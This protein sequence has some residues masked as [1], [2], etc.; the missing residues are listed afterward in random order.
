MITKELLDVAKRQRDGERISLE[1][2]K[3][4][5]ARHRKYLEVH[6]MYSEKAIH[7]GIVSEFD[8]RMDDDF[9]T[10]PKVDLVNNMMGE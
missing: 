10:T 3:E 7:D 4:L 1:E 6:D 2:F 5:D 9:M 8:L